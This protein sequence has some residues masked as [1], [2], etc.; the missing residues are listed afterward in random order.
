MASKEG[1]VYQNAPAVLVRSTIGAR[2]SMVAGL[3]Y[4][5]K[6]QM[7]AKEMLRYGVACGSATTMSEGTNLGSIEN[8]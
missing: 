4:C 1:I 6:Q 7:S 5:I 3:I 8:I 2:D